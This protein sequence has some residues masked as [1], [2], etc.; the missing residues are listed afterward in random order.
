MSCFDNCYFLSGLAGEGGR[1]RCQNSQWSVSSDQ[2]GRRGCGGRR[3]PQG[4]GG[5]GDQE[6]WCQHGSG[7]GDSMLGRNRLGKM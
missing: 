2:R 7:V 4:Q 3:V 1:P 5:V 6:T